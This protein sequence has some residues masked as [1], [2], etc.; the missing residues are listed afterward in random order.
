MNKH[1]ESIVCSF[2]GQSMTN[3]LPQW[4]PSV[5][6]F[7]RSQRPT[8][9]EVEAM[10]QMMGLG[11]Q[12]SRLMQHWAGDTSVSGIVEL[13]RMT[14]WAGLRYGW[15][16]TTWDDSVPTAVSVWIPPGVRVPAW[17]QAS[18]LPSMVRQ[19]GLTQACLILR[20]LIVLDGVHSAAD[21][22]IGEHAYLLTIVT[23][24]GYRRQGHFARLMMPVVDWCDHVGCAAYLESDDT[25]ESDPDKWNRYRYRNFGF[26]LYGNGIPVSAEALRLLYPAMIR[27]KRPQHS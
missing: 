19:F 13:M 18:L 16:A 5:T 24:P 23:H 27:P 21:R 2:Q 26:R 22:E 12:S 15:V 10:A 3:E 6:V 11:F 4:D 17:W 20:D 14:L 25:G 8:R 1:T 9:D 7:S